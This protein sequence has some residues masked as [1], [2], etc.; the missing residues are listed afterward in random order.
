M[1]V[2][3]KLGAA[4]QLSPADAA[5]AAQRANTYHHYHPTH[6]GHLLFKQ[7]VE[8]DFQLINGHWLRGALLHQ[9]RSFF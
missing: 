4:T 8:K 3:L 2:C 9:I 5:T 1:W 6:I 7:G